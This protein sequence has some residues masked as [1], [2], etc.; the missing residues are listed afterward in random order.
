MRC[1]FPTVMTGPHPVRLR[2]RE[3]LA[4]RPP[5]QQHQVGGAADRKAPVR[6]QPHCIGRHVRHRRRPVRVRPVQVAN[7]ARLRARK[8]TS[9]AA[10][11][12]CD[13]GEEQAGGCVMG[14]RGHACESKTGCA[15]SVSPA[16]HHPDN[17]GGRPCRPGRQHGIYNHQQALFLWLNR[18]CEWVLQQCPIATASWQPSGSLPC[19]RL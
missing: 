15:S 7:P 6:G 11:H 4:V 14:R 19:H 10:S 2:A 17:L 13:Y 9:P 18:A 3:H 1:I 12:S 5:A 8:M 16:S